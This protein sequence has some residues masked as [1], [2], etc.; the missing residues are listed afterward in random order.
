MADYQD[1]SLIESS[2]DQLRKYS[3][4]NDPTSIDGH[5]T[6]PHDIFSVPEI[7]DNI[8]DLA[9]SGSRVQAARVCQNWSSSSLDR[10]WRELPSILP[11]LELLSPLTAVANQWV[12]PGSHI[13]A[14]NV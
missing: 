4:D 13:D 14:K 5:V 10:I 12:R 6:A 1:D 2:V 7:I 11:L 9:T 8:L 3:M